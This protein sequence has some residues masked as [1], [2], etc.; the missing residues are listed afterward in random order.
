LKALRSYHEESSVDTQIRTWLTNSQLL[1]DKRLYEL[2]F[3]ELERAK[4]MAI[5]H[6][7]YS[8]LI[9]IC[10]LEASIVIEHKPKELFEKLDKIVAE[11][12]KALNALNTTS[13][14][15]F[16]ERRT[17]AFVRSSY[18]LRGED[19][20]DLL[21]KIIN[22]EILAQPPSAV[23][24]AARIHYLK[25]QA[26]IAICRGDFNTTSNIYDDMI[27]IWESDSVRLKEDVL[28]YKKLLS[29]KLTTL[30]ACNEFEKM[31]ALLRK[32]KSIPCH[33]AEE[34]A[35]QF[36][37]TYFME[38][39]LRMNTDQFG[40]FDVF[41]AQID[42]GIKKYRTKVNQARLQLFYYNISVCYFSLHRWK[43]ALYWLMKIIDQQKTDH[44]KDI[45]HFARLFRLVLFYELG[46]HDLLEY[47]L[48][49][50]ERYLRQQKAWFT[51]ES[52]IVKFLKKI[53][54]SNEDER[55]L[56][57]K[58]FLAQLQEVS[59]GQNSA[60]LPGITELQLWTT[61]RINNTPIRQLLN[62]KNAS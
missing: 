15:Y 1:L 25:I 48:I 31:P 56:H 50:T 5:R 23:L 14:I 2:S 29:N 32:I 28:E 36:Q 52:A 41:V 3:K 6:E 11:A 34:E 46:K 47:E 57:F 35:E 49:N 24:R 9:Q 33:N 55:S 37:N 61:Y 30:H 44:R 60:A 42:A 51:F 38:L 54:A 4:K 53:L 12:H 8:D 18:Q 43:D 59:G 22:D 7:H 62:E 20:T 21:E 19:R 26:S 27:E 58:K 45:Q 13:K 10:Q 40:G 16:I 17:F 39:L